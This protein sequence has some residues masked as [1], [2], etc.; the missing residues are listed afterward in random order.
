MP[1]GDFE[2]KVAVVTGS[3]G[4]IGAS[5]AATLAS[6][7]ASVVVNDLDGD[8]AGAAAEKIVADGGTAIGVAADVS[9]PADVERLMGAA[10]DGFGEI[11]VLVNN[12]A[13]THQR[14]FLDY[15]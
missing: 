6:R 4:G 9:G 2:S 8:I 10:R 3:G 11:D 7:G 13:V 14:A 1:E 12:A 15:T 5:I